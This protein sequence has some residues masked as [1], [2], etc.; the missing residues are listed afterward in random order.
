MTVSNFVSKPPLLHEQDCM[1]QVVRSYEKWTGHARKWTG[2][3]LIRSLKELRNRSSLSRIL[4]Q[5]G[6]GIPIHSEQGLSSNHAMGTTPSSYQSS[7]FEQWV[8]LWTGLLVCTDLV[9]LSGIMNRGSYENACFK[10]HSWFHLKVF[11]WVRP[12]YLW[13]AKKLRAGLLACIDKCIIWHFW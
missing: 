13:L 7:D 12:P 6:T 9:F 10:S 2:A 5:S 11:K 8:G 3:S 1:N 4:K